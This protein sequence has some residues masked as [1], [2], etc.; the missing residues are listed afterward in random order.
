MSVSERDDVETMMA[1]HGRDILE[2]VELR[3]VVDPL[4]DW[5]CID[6]PDHQHLEDEW[7]RSDSW[8]SAEDVR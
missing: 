8:L 3:S 6:H 7:I 5:I 4:E 2:A 1:D